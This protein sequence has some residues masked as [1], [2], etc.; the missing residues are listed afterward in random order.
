MSINTPNPTEETVSFLSGLCQRLVAHGIMD[1]KKA[2]QYRARAK[3]EKISLIDYLVQQKIVAGHSL[4]NLLTQD[5]GLSLINLECFDP[6]QIPQLY[7]N[8][9]LVNKH[10]AI[11]IFTRANQLYV[12]LSDPTNMQ[13]LDEFKFSTGLRTVGILAESH[14]LRQFIDK[15]FEN[16]KSSVMEDINH[17]DGKS[18]E[19]I[20]VIAAKDLNNPDTGDGDA[21]D[22]PVV[23]FVNKLL[24]DAINKFVSDIHFEPYENFYRVRF[25]GDGILYEVATPPISLAPRITARLKVMSQLDISE[26]R[27]P[28]DGHFKFVLSK[29]RSIDFRISTC[30]TLGGEKIVIRLL[31]PSHLNI[32]LENLGFSKEQK[33]KFESAIHHPHGMIIVTGPTGSGKTIT[34]YS[35]L[36]VLNNNERNIY[37]IEDPVEMNIR[38]INQ[39]NV[40][41]KIGLGFSK[42]LRSFL[43]QDPDIIMVGEIRDLETAEIAVKASQTGH[44]VLSTLHTNSASKTLSRLINM[45][46]EPFNIATSVNL[47]IAQRLARKL[48]EHCKTTLELSK[49]A[50]ERAGFSSGSTHFTVFSPGTNNDNCEHC[51]DG[52]KGRLGIFEVLPMTAAI[53]ETIIKGGTSFEIERTAQKEGMITL[54]ES[55]LQKVK[56]GITSLEEANRITMD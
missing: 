15:V 5:F 34:L 1:G 7:L 38:G 29:H 56:E 4:A 52:Y 27:L 17:E 18:L 35:A 48:C 21:D 2:G 28:Q 23:R 42:A 24:I 19:A 44:L 47:I 49:D 3:Q 45:G 37:T 33:E 36:E 11:P 39:V 43:R 32:G 26:R 10:H 20:N 22:A 31:D 41:L 55:A 30:P 8:S 50:L 16:Q 46:I 25:R 54:R 9:K 14:K 53:S 13:A 51:K 12:A 40:N 6:H